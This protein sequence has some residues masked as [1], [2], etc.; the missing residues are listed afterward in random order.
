MLR[1]GPGPMVQFGIGGRQIST[2]NASIATCIRVSSHWRS[3][4]EP[5][6]PLH[7]PPTSGASA[8]AA[9]VRGLLSPVE[10]WSDPARLRITPPARRA[11]PIREGIIKDCAPGNV[12]PVSRDARPAI[13][14]PRAIE[15]VWPP[16]RWPPLAV[17]LARVS[18]CSLAAESPRAPART[19]AIP[20][21]HDTRRRL[22]VGW[23]HIR[24]RPV[25][26]RSNRHGYRE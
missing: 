13:G 22:R 8:N 20:R 5:T 16:M 23:P 2:V 17:P 6:S 19:A 24:P 11:A 25:G 15:T 21:Q 4:R 3:R 12:D 9:L 10:P 7:G 1:M 18:G 14:T 26:V